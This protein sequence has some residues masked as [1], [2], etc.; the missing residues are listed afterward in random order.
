MDSPRALHMY[1]RCFIN[2]LY[3]WCLVYK[4]IVRQPLLKLAWI[5][6]QYS[7]LPPNTKFPSEGGGSGEEYLDCYDFFLKSVISIS[8]IVVFSQ[9]NTKDYITFMFH[10]PCI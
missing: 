9:K 3:A 10:K 2:E 7:K 5:F 1:K 6:F 4:D 8:I